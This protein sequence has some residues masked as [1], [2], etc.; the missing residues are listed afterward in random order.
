MTDL[1]LGL[2]VLAVA[3]LAVAVFYYAKRSAGAGNPQAENQLR[4]EAAGLQAKAD[5]LR[6]QITA[7]DAQAADL[8]QRLEAEQGARVKAET[9]LDA[10]RRSFE[11]QR[12]LLDEA[13][14]KLKDAF[15]ALSADALKGNREQF[16]S[17]AEERL[18]PIQLLLGT[19][20][21]HLRD[22]EAARN[23][24]YGSLQQA[25]KSL[26][27]DQQLL[28][29]EAARLTTALKSPTVRGRWG[30]VTL[31]RV[32]E[33]AG[34]S[35]YC[36]FETQ[37]SVATGEDALQRPDMIVKLPNHRT[38]VVDSKVPMEAY[39]RATDALDEA[40]RKAAMAEHAQAVRSRVRALGQQ[41]YWRQFQPAPDFVVLFLPQE[42]SFSAALE[43][44]R[45]LIEDGMKSGVVLATPTTLI[46]LLRAVAYGWR[47]EELAENA[48]RIAD[49]GKQL[50]D[51]I[52]TFA[53][54][55][56]GVGDGL[57]KA[58]KAYD[59]AVGS[60]ERMLVPGARRLAELGAGDDKDLPELP[61]AEGPA[62]TVT[63]PPADPMR[64][65][66]AA[67]E[68]GEAHEP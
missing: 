19:Y 25:L 63:P 64:S 7:L 28:R 44:D 46:A 62:R 36:D 27:Q 59:K 50:Y 39:L 54:H 43:Q 22:I 45:E 37:V 52:R 12:A 35:A 57:R 18:K 3:A 33:V 1:L 8:R 30:E 34:M 2:L 67:G 29:T 24:A 20:E 58:G 56:D 47:Q 38:I 26:A 49:A 4:A 5:E 10:E 16:L 6:G 53:E 55:L 68:G 13:Q 42:S 32:V 11:E 31:K 23:A 15:A 14:V 41:S 21:Q 60:Y 65:L 51:R 48:E 66:P 40:S 17:H 9:R 61:T